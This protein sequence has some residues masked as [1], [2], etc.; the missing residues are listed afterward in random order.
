MNDLYDEAFMEHCNKFT[1]MNNAAGEE[2]LEIIQLTR[3]IW[4]TAFNCN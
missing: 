2:R 1:D 3:I 4:I